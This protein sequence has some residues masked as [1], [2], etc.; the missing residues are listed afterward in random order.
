MSYEICAVSDIP[1]IGSR[2][3]PFIGR[4]VHVYFRPGRPAANTCL[5]FGGTLACQDRR[6]VCE[7]HGAVFDMDSRERLEG[8]APANAK[9]M[10]LS[11]IVEGGK[12]IYVWGGR[13]DITLVS[14]HLCPYVQRVS[15]ALS[16]K[17]VPFDRVYI[18]LSDKPD[19]FLELSPLGKTPVLKYGNNAIFESAVILE[20]LEETQPRPLHL[21]LHRAGR[22]LRR[23]PGARRGDH[24]DLPGHPPG[25]RAARHRRGSADADALPALPRLLRRAGGVG[26]LGLPR[27]PVQVRRQP[28]APPRLGRVLKVGSA[29]RPASR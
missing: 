25:G 4:D 27:R 28:G 1:E 11:T 26:A 12:L 3:V 7:W 14:H 20:F 18:D 23:P 10:F 6:M 16:E 8:A 2:A 17:S 13:D 9:L 15:I 22:G 24:R 29:S 5:H 19:W 21:P